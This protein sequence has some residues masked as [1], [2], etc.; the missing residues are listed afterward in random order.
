M[1]DCYIGFHKSEWCTD[2]H[3]SFATIDDPNWGNQP[4]ALPIIT[5]DF[6]FSS[7][8]RR[9]THNIAATPDN[10]IIFTSL[11]FLKQKNN[12]NG[13]TLTY[14]CRMESH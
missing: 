3:D 5:V 14:R 4:N 7:T 8:T 13:Q 1:L 6:S 11:C 2:N 9:C 10:A 12:D